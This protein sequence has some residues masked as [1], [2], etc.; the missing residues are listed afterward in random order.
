MNKMIRVLAGLMSL[1]ML[2]SVTACKKIDQESSIPEGTEI[3]TETV[4]SEEPVKDASAQVIYWL[5]DYDINPADGNNRSVA[6]TLFEDQFGGKISWIPCT[7]E[8]KLDTLTSRILIDEPVDMLPYEPDMFPAGVINNQFAPLDDYLDLN[9]PVWDGMREAI[10]M[11]ADQGQHYVVP[12][13][14]SDT[15][16]ITYSRKMCQENGLEDPYVLYQK[17]EW[18]WDVFMEMMKTFTAN[19]KERYGIC[20]SFGQALIQSTG[21]TVIGFDGEQFSNHIADTDI[22]SAEECMAEIQRLKLYD[23]GWYNHFPEAQNI[24]FYSM[25]DWSVGGSVSANPDADLMVVPFPK[26]PDADTYYLT[27]NYSARM[28]VKGSDK[29]EAVAQYIYCER[30]AETEEAYRSAVKAL[31]LAEDNPVTGGMTEEQY[32]AIE[33]YR[34][35]HLTVFDYGYGMGMYTQN[36]YTDETKGIMNHLINEKATESWAVRRDRYAPQIDSILETYHTARQ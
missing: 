30:V 6:L 27:G 5:A 13:A 9:D 17:G 33:A 16:L 10:D 8:N 18:D 2:F 21:K 20:G 28:L 25:P 1:T 26:S 23:A 32:E 24:L 29:G 31:K 36:A 22:E 34:Q 4:P 11:Y 35:N 14:V 15:M 12:Y 3:M 19:G 7:A